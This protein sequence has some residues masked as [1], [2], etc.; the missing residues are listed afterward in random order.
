MRPFGGHILFF[1]DR[2]VTIQSSRGRRL[3]WLIVISIVAAIVTGGWYLLRP[4]E[5]ELNFTLSDINGNVFWLDDFKGQVVLLDFMATWCGPCQASMP[6]L[7]TLHEEFKE[8]VVIIS[9]SVDP[10]FDTEQRLRDWMDSWDAQWVHAQDLADPPVSQL[11]GVTGIPT[12][13]I[14]DKNGHIRYRYVG[15]TSES[16]LRENLSTLL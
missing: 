6:G 14:L 9:I 11:F 12:Y 4:K 8:R 7:K 15:L 10:V 1:N 5:G 13:V 2:N 16:T 3:R